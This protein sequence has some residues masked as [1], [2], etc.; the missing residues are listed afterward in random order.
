[1]D[2]IVLIGIDGGASK[3]LAHRVEILVDPL[4]FSP[5]EPSIEVSYDSSDLY[6]LGFEPV[7][8]EEQLSEHRAG[9]V[10]QTEEE[11]RREGAVID[12]FFRAISGLKLGMT[13][14]P[15]VVGIGL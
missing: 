15:I 8:L 7:S 11:E 3:V 4:R 6:E 12:S 5:R 1:M 10:R 14:V 9:S 2:E 13:A